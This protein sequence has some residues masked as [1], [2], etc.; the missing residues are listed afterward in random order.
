MEVKS[1]P[2]ANL[3]IETQTCQILLVMLMIQLIYGHLRYENDSYKALLESLS[4]RENVKHKKIGLFGLQTDSNSLIFVLHTF[5]V[6][7]EDVN[8]L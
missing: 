8:I 6:S 1:W 3:R 5:S 2:L 4:Y 7:E